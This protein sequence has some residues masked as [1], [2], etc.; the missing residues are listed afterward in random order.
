MA[1]RT[2]PFPLAFMLPHI[3]WVME[4]GEQVYSPFIFPL[5]HRQSIITGGPVIVSL[6]IGMFMQMNVVFRRPS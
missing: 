3:L 1:L 6:C 4:M 5:D 2:L